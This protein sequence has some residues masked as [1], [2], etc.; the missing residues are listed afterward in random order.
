MN[1]PPKTL[2]MLLAL[3]ICFVIFGGLTAFAGSPSPIS[4]EEAKFFEVEVRPLLAEKCF[5]C[6]GEEKQRGDLRLDTLGGHLAGGESGAAVVPGKID[7]SLLI[8]AV[9]YEGFEMPPS[10]KLPDKQIKILERWV[11][12][13]A[14]WPG[15]DPSA[16]VRTD[17]PKLTE[18][19]RQ[20]WAFQP[21]TNPP[22]PTVVE[23]PTPATQGSDQAAASYRIEDWSK[24]P[25]DAFILQKQQAANLSPAPPADRA[26]LLR[27]LSYDLTGLP[28]T[29]EQV[30]EFIEDSSPD[31]YPKL[32]ERLLDSPQYGER[33]ARHWLDLV[34]YADS[35]GYRADFYRPDAW[36]YRDYVIRSLNEDKPYDRFVTEQIAGDEMYPD[37]PDALIATGYLRHWIYEYNSRDARGQW[38]LIMNDITDTT[39]DVFLGMGMQCA[40]CH[41]HKFDPILQRD[42]FRLR[43][44]F[45]AVL[46][47]DGTVVASPEE[48]AEHAKQ[49]AIWEKKTAS[50]QA[51]IDKIEAP[52][53]VSAAKRAIIKFP[54][55][56]Q[57]IMDKTSEERSPY[58]HQIHELVHRQVLFE[59]SR[60]ESRLK[61][62]DKTAVLE[63]KKQLGKMK[64]EKPKPLPTA[65]TIEDL[66]TEAPPVLIPKRSKDPV[67]PGVL[68]ILDPSP[69]DYTPNTELQSTGRRTAFAKWLT[70]PDNPLSTR[71]IVN[72]IWQYHFSRGLAPNSSDF[73]RL[74]GP[75]SHPELLDWLTTQF[76]AN[77][78]SFK[79]LHRQIV[80]SET[81]RQSSSHPQMQAFQEID[82]H[83][84]RYWRGNVLRLD[85]EQIRDSVLMVSGRL[86][87]RAGGPSTLSDVPRRSIYTRVMRN[88]RDPLMDVF[89]LPQFFSS[90]SSRNRT[91]T[92][93]QSLLLINSPIYLQHATA[94]ASR[95]RK[96]EQNPSERVRLAW[97]LISGREPT[98]DELEA[99][100]SFLKEQQKRLEADDTE[101]TST[102]VAARLPY[103]DG[104]A[105][106]LM[107]Q[108]DLLLPRRSNDPELDMKNMTI[109]TF[110]QIRSVYTSGMVRPLMAKWSPNS[111][112]PGW[113][114]GVSGEGSRRKPRTLILHM[115]GEK[116]SGDFGEAAV[117]S[118]QDVKLDTP[119]FVA[120]AFQP[121]TKDSKGTVTFYLKDLSN[122]EEPM[123]IA[124]IEHDI[125]GGLGN[126]E[127]LTIGGR[128]NGKGGRFDGLIDDV[129]ISD[130]TL[131]K[132]QLMLFAPNPLPATVAYWKFEAQPGVLKDST[133]NKFD[134]ETSVSDSGQGTPA[135]AALIDFCHSLLNSNEFLY[136]R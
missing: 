95:I 110:F 109:E 37:D 42:Y 89:D 113:S 85:A 70:Q 102:L 22:V 6:H 108:K 115:W 19:D 49:Q 29:P 132:E 136:V 12:L 41:D 94:F 114:F 130:T 25:I 43:A 93:I 30:Q 99:S 5:S 112:Q 18:E 7:E 36:Q 58:E 50:I 71:V 53:R 120:A 74:G 105:V 66:G 101:S 82:P 135:D 31:A 83:N 116:V 38:D 127:P 124:V 48:L 98:T 126:S 27:R 121:A 75:P 54:A 34:R 129:R 69:L 3:L 128:T 133:N 32:V 76:V 4:P 14:P 51:K 10:G 13:G 118:D 131:N 33:W 67:E 123:N 107:D 125:V 2:S 104:Q 111:K 103:R 28:P 57:L 23:I 62:E 26:A 61:K 106:A 119:Y 45:A 15:A 44:V 68:T 97:R 60:L 40:R 16:P 63:L 21:L 134:L 117:F 90:E 55:D 88:A 47:K 79:W 39:G 20:W 9:R 11:S 59:Y 80:L 65:M 77:G 52:Y 91:T 96:A 64:A 46:P 35:D 1:I 72:R 56:V 87:E 8:E 73:G 100:L 78:W 122:E 84:E 86:D 92:P 24:N 17:K 81:Y